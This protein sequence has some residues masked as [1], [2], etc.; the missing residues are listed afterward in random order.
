MKSVK[1]IQKTDSDDSS[2]I[3]ADDIRDAIVSGE[4]TDRK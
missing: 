2:I 3:L 4:L 1:D